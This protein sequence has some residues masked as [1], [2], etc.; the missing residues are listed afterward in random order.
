MPVAH[1]NLTAIIYD[2]KGN[3]L[4]IGKNSYIK[5]HPLQAKRAQE[6]GREAAVFLHAEIHAIV[7]CRDLEQAHRIFIARY[8]RNGSPRLAKPCP[9][10]QHALTF[11]PIKVIDY[12][13]G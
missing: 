11:T 9:I 4:S 5:T 12:T 8:D 2:K 10:C 6:V 13:I 1:Q 3:V 7:R